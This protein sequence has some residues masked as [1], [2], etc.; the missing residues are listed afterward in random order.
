[1]VLFSAAGNLT[2]VYTTV[3][4]RLSILF[5]GLSIS[6]LSNILIVRTLVIIVETKYSNLIGQEEMMNPGDGESHDSSIAASSTA[7][8]LKA[9]LKWMLNLI[10]E[11]YI[12]LQDLTTIRKRYLVITGVL[13]LPALILSA[14]V[15][16]R[17]PQYRACVNCDVFLELAVSQ[18]ILLC[19]YCV[20]LFRGAYLAY[21]VCGFDSK[22]VVLEVLLVTS[23][24]GGMTLIGW[25]LFIVDPNDLNFNNQFN[26]AF[27]FGIGGYLMWII[28]FVA[29]IAIEFRICCGRSPKNK[30]RVERKSTVL[31]DMKAVV[32]KNST[33]DNDLKKDFTEFARKRYCVEIV[34]FINDTDMY[35]GIFHEKRDAWRLNKFRYLAKTYAISGSPQEINV[36]SAI[37]VKITQVYNNA[38]TEMDTLPLF[39][40]FDDA[41]QEIEKMARDGIWA[42]FSRNHLNEYEIGTGQLVARD[43]G[44]HTSSSRPSTNK[45]FTWKSKNKKAATEPNN[46]NGDV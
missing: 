7:G 23:I 46:D 28:G 35:K 31:P 45:R 8:A 1:M 24:P 43:G 13:F 39:N 30:K 41:I 10:P 27:F 21:K 33:T 4:C 44:N 38:S 15:V 3:P 40:I 20:I 26:W 6:T 42:E 37:R 34:N 36:P 19:C 29:Q 2:R 18:L 11:D 9:L 12:T 25:I 32:F 16:I 22:G 5:Y 14:S 17:A